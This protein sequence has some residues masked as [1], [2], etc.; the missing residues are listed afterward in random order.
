MPWGFMKKAA[1]SAAG[2]YGELA[3]EMENFKP[4]RYTN[5]YGTS[6]MTPEGASFTPTEEFAQR[7]KEIGDFFGQANR[8]LLAFNQGNASDKTLALLRRRRA[9]QFDPMLANLESRLMK[10]GRLGL[11]TGAY[12]ANP[13]MQGFF[14]AEAGADLEAQLIAEQEA[15]NQGQ[16]LYGMAT[17]ARGLFD[18]VA[19]PN[20]NNLFRTADFIQNTRN[21]AIGLKAAGVETML[22]ARKAQDAQLH[23]VGMQFF[24]M[25]GGNGQQGNQN[26]TSNNPM[27][28]TAKSSSGASGS[29]NSGGSGGSGNSGYDYGYGGQGFSNFFGG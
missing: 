29:S 26:F 20:A 6:T 13:E 2:R 4:I 28:S 21:N 24:A 27:G 16:Y 23:D 18:S 22:Q 1:S 8:N 5:L 12:G 11:A 14:A 17:G 3:S 9:E 10:Q 7:Q 15:R 19:D 25:F